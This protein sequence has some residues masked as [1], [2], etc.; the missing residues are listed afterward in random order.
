MKICVEVILLNIEMIFFFLPATLSQNQMATA[1][2]NFISKKQT[3]HC[4]L[5]N[6]QNLSK[7]VLTLLKVRQV[8]GSKL[9]GICLSLCLLYVYDHVF[10]FFFLNST[11]THH[12][13]RNAIRFIISG[14]STL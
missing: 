10:S 8:L 12:F 6:F 7:Y 9:L 13:Y 11:S 14:R 2:I 1:S 5:A 3:V 4:W